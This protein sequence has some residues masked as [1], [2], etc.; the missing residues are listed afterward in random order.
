M[1]PEY[2]RRLVEDGFARLQR[3]VREESR[4]IDA[5]MA[6]GTVF[7]RMHGAAGS[8]EPYLLKVEAGLYPVGPWRVGFVDPEAQGEERLRLP[9]HDPRYW[10]FSGLPG[11]NGGF[12]VSYPGPFRVFVC[13]PFTVE[14]FHYHGDVRWEPWAYGLDRVVI[15]VSDAVRKADHFSKWYPLVRTGRL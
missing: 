3:R 13:H 4:E 5:E 14:F 6:G 1:D 2:Q 10:P 11:L 7:A 12:H 15:Q 9:D 8:I